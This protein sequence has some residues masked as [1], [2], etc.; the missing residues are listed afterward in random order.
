MSS[1]AAPVSNTHETSEVHY[2][3]QGSSRV[4]RIEE[5]VLFF[6]AK[7]FN[8]AAR[9]CDISG[10]CYKRALMNMNP[11]TFGGIQRL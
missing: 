9:P 2:K 6:R 4:S 1:I 8:S 10:H 5:L 11:S 7:S 3:Q